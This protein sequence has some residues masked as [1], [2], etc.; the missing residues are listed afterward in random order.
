MN[1]DY[2]YEYLLH[3]W[4]GFWNDANIEIHKEPEI[5]YKWFN[6]KEERQVEIDRLDAINKKYNLPNSIIAKTFSEGYLTRY[7]FVIESLIKF[8]DKIIRVENNLG[9]GFY[10][11]EEFD[12]LGNIAE[13]IKEWKYDICLDEDIYDNH[14]RLYSTLILR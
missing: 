1:K 10:S 2:K 11:I 7:E 13:Y 12:Q 6:T 5:N 4:G 9:Y 14:E 8:K 3:V